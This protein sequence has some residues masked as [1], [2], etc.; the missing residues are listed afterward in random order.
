MPEDQSAAR[1]P[2]WAVLG[3]ANIVRSAFLPA[4]AEAGGAPLVVGSRDAG[5]AA[6]FAAETGIAAGVGSY[7][8]A[9]AHPGVDAVYVALPNSLHAEWSAA[10]LAAGKAVLCEKPLCTSVPEAQRLLTD[11]SAGGAL[12]WEAFV[13][14][15]QAQW[16]R[17]A[18]LLADGAIGELREISAA[19]H[20][21]LPMD[22]GDIRLQPGLG[23]GSLADV[24]CYPVRFAQL[25][26]E[27]PATR[28]VAS[29]V[30]PAELGVD[31][32]AAAILDYPGERRLELSCGFRRAT[33]IFARLLG[34]A[35]TIVLTNPYHARPSDS[36]TI[37]RPG[38][39]PIVERPS[40]DRW[41]FTGALRH[42]SAAV[43]GDEAP[44]H[45]ATDDS[46]ATARALADIAE[47]WT[48][49]PD[50]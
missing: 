23:G 25:L 9:I 35:G 10:A 21:P 34:D 3:T 27:A 12:L 36:I 20:F 32:E 8:E 40:L 15:F 6:A 48:R 41:S 47:A 49:I 1:S 24:G 11:A 2:G 39:D 18:S 17:L 38:Q 42:I 46:L 13:F 45:L 19:F 28:A 22:T 43:R 50:D 5:R 37:R 44:R 29:A 14:P 4:L 31:V 30:V 26:F 7:Q 33:D 16:D